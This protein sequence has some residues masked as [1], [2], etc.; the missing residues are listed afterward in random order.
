MA[1]A[2]LA[3][4]LLAKR[5]QR[6]TNT[7]EGLKSGAIA[8]K[9][10]K[11]M[12]GACLV[13]SGPIACW[14]ILA[15]FKSGSHKAEAHNLTYH[16]GQSMKLRSS[17]STPALPDGQ[18]KK[19]RSMVRPCNGSNQARRFGPLGPSLRSYQ[20]SSSR[21]GCRIELQVGS[22]PCLAKT[23]HH[24]HRS[25]NPDHCFSQSK[26]RL[27]YPQLRELEPVGHSKS[28]TF[29]KSRFTLNLGSESLW[30][31]QSCLPGEFEVESV[32]CA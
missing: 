16:L 1:L 17:S 21:P 5:D 24:H 3:A 19:R 25:K 9:G 29:L 32:G 31:F 26:V 14:Q 13:L 11:T 30:S 27:A 8:V 28:H 4:S 20:R 10:R 18:C 23:E 12:L 7:S 22:E 2:N 15:T 6:A